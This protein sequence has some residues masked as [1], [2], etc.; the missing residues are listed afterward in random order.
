MAAIVQFAKV[1]AGTPLP[2]TPDTFVAVRAGLGY[3]LHLTDDAGAPFKLNGRVNPAL[4]VDGSRPI[5]YIGRSDMIIK[6]DY[7]GANVVR[8]IVATTN[9]ETDWPNR[10][11]F[12]YGVI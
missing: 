1:L 10:A 8:S 9:L 3:D 12:T 7:S 6:L 2:A 5:G 11:S 4:K